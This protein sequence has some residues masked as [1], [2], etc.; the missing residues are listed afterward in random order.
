MRRTI[1]SVLL[2]VT[3]V[4]GCGRERKEPDAGSTSAPLAVTPCQSDADCRLVAC[5]GCTCAG[6][7]RSDPDPCGLAI[8]AAWPCSGHRVVCDP[9]AHQCRAEMAGGGPGTGR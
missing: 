3:G 1:L 2:L 5:S 9:G 7:H 8:C 6:A 4:L